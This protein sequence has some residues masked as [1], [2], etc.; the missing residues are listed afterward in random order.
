[1]KQYIAVFEGDSPDL[2]SLGSWH[3]FDA[4]NDISAWKKAKKVAKHT[5][6]GYITGNPPKVLEIW[7]SNKSYYKR[8]RKL[9]DEATCIKTEQ[10]KAKS[11]NKQDEIIPL[12]NK[13]ENT[14]EYHIL[15]SNKFNVYSVIFEGKGKDLKAYCTCPAGKKGGKFCKH[16]S[17]LLNQD[18]AN[19]VEPSDKIEAL[20]DVLLGS[21][22]L[23]K[24][25]DYMN[26]RE[27]NWFVYN[28]VKIFAVD[29]L[30]KYLKTMIPDKFIIE[31]NKEKSR[32]ALYKVEYFKNGNPKH[33]IKN[34]MVCMEY[35]VDLTYFKIGHQAY[36]HFAHA[37]PS[38]IENIKK[39]GGLSMNKLERPPDQ[40]DN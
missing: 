1:M 39:A 6:I 22:L 18:M 29:D 2:D 9:P 13:G 20:D 27:L 4:G 40:K 3:P 21:S 26:K 30:Y 17:G 15:S 16:I 38:F 32:L 35:D 11:L 19:I 24:N 34:R 14:L 23:S 31:F 33:S 8:I 28:D 7:E 10:E 5:I 25:D 12:K 36:R 37:G